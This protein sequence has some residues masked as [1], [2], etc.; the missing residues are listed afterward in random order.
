M[1]ERRGRRRCLTS[2]RRGRGRA[3]SRRSRRRP[4]A[5]WRTTCSGMLER[6]Y[7][8]HVGHWKH[9]GL[10]GRDGLRRRRHRPLHRPAGGVPRRHG[11]PHLRVNQPSAWFY[12]SDALRQLCD[13]WEKHGSGLTNMHGSTGDIIFL[14][15]HRRAL[16]PMLRRA[17]PTSASTSAARAPTCARRAAAAARRAASGRATTP[18]APATT[19]PRPSRT[20]CTAR[21]SPTST[22]SSSPAAP[23]TASPRSRAPTVGHRHLEGRHPG[24][25][26]EGRRVRQERR[27]HPEARSA[28]SA[29]PAA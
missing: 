3:S 23:T 19:S 18:W 2:S 20:S 11:V 13:I 16:E 29:R 25:P 14:G 15:D 28:T 7:E 9:G 21:R 5:R 27:R 8:E 4:T 24:R 6:S 17:Q 12:T 26:G 10:V 22:S 1:S